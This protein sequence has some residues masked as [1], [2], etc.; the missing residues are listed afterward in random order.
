MNDLVTWLRAQLDD[1]ERVA[2]QASSWTWQPELAGEH[3]S[4]AHIARWNPA[5]VL[6]DVDA[7]R[8]ILALGGDFDV[9]SEP[10]T[11]Q[12]VWERA[13]RLLALPYADRPG[14]REEWRP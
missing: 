11:A 3:V 2:E 4:T 13:V 9:Y 8:C 10:Y 12:P 7:K 6:A 14:F 5:R 1:D